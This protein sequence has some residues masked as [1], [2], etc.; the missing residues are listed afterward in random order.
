[1][2]LSS[3]IKFDSKVP[4]QTKNEVVVKLV[5]SFYNPVLWQQSRL[6]LEITSKNNSGFLNW[7]F[8]NNSDGSYSGHYVAMEVGTYELCVSVDRTLFNSCPF[9]VNVYSSKKRAV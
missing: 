2:M 9:V 7:A 3:I 5:D 6:K 4:K 1:M 8:V